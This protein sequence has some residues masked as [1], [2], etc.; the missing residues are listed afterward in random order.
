MTRPSLLA[1]IGPICQQ[2]TPCW[3]TMAAWYCWTVRRS[4][5]AIRQWRESMERAREHS[6]R[7]V[8]K[9]LWRIVHVCH[10]ESG[11]VFNVNSDTGGRRPRKEVASEGGCQHIPTLSVVFQFCL[12]ALLLCVHICLRLDLCTSSVHLQPIMIL[13]VVV[14]SSPLEKR[15]IYPH[16][17]INPSQHFPHR[18]GAWSLMLLCLRWR[19]NCWKYR[20]SYPKTESC[21]RLR[22]KSSTFRKPSELSSRRLRRVWRP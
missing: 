8:S 9:T 5:V 14:G 17:N 4:V 11:H 2:P 20:R 22:N 21:S 18:S 16:V 12:S 10:S 7:G 1:V 13:T 6:A 19:H 15:H 3:K